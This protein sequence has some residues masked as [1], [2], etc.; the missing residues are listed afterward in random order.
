MEHRQLGNTGVQI[1]EIGLGA[2]QMSLSGRPAREQSLAVI[3]RALELGVNFID[4]ADAYCTDETEKHHNE[5]LLAE[6]FETYDGDTSEVLVAT[7]GGLVRPEGRWETDGTPNRLRRTIRESFEALG[8]DRP[9]DVWQHH[10]PDTDYTIEEQLEPVA[11]AVAEGLVRFVGVSNYSTEQIDQAREVVEVVSVQNQYN[12][13]HRK[14]E[15]DGVLEYCEANSITFLP[16]SPLGGASRCEKL[17]DIDALQSI[18]RARDTSV[19]QVVL[20][21]LQSKSD[22]IVPIPG[23]SRIASITDSLQA[24]DLTLSEQEISEFEAAI[25]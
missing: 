15:H 20:A 14:P 16:W 12:P 2:M 5:E 3:H 23:A 6:A 24:A 18:A 13:W 9:I 11:D 4:T 25:A 19:Y 10:A 21:W 8:G 22:Q 1:S 17:E 7:K